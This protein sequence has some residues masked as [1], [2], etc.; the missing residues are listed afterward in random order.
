MY[1]LIEYFFLRIDSHITNNI[2][3]DAEPYLIKF[4]MAPLH[5]KDT[6][7]KQTALNI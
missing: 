3:L 2:Q 5:V 6:E 1:Q 4:S 7:E